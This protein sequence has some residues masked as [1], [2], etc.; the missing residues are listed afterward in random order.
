MTV[1]DDQSGLLEHGG[2]ADRL[3]NPPEH[4]AVGD[5][6]PRDINMFSQNQQVFIVKK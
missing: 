4:P 2:Q 6:A 1:P 3:R 5:P